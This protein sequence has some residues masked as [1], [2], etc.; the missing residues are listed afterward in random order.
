M[1]KIVYAL[2]VAVVCC[3]AFSCNEKPKSYRFVKV[4]ADG[5][6]EVENIQATNDTDA[7]NLY[8]DKME[9]IIVEVIQKQEQPYE[10]MYVISP[11]GDTLNTNKELLEAVSKSLPTMV[12]MPVETKLS[13]DTVQKDR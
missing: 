5:K 1:K 10:S 8:F 6:E 3:G 13:S 2:L 4:T 11:D 9:K 12:N 7:L